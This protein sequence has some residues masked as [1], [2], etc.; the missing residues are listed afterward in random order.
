[1]VPYV[2]D[3]K[4][5][6]HRIRGLPRPADVGRAHVLKR[7]TRDDAKLY[8]LPG[9]TWWLLIGPE[10]SDAR[11]VTLGRAEFPPGSAPPGHVHDV[12]EEV[13]Y[14]L[15][16]EGKLVTPEGEAL[17]R[18]GDAVFIP[19]GLHH[20]TVSTGEDTLELLSI[21]SPPVIPGSYEA[22]ADDGG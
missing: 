19:S 7:V 21:F 14:I 17:L 3:G 2:A 10:T 15:A 20:A 11:K 6:H 9:R 8:T 16:G 4:V 13:I 22:A 18:P 12:E 5:R 1:M